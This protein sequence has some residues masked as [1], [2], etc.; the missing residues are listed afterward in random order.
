[1]DEVSEITAA[2]FEESMKFE[3]YI[4]SGATTGV[5]DS[6]SMSAA[7]AADDDDLYK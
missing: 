6:F 4:G 7:S 3:T 1:M 5:A 2:H